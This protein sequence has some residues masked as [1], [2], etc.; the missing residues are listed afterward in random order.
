MNR[1]VLAIFK[2]HLEEEL[3]RPALAPVPNVTRMTAG[4]SFPLIL[5]LLSSKGIRPAAAVVS[6]GIYPGGKPDLVRELHAAFPAA[7]VVLAAR[8]PEP[9]PPLSRLLADG[10]RHVVIDAAEG[11]VAPS[12]LSEALQGLSADPAW[13]PSQYLAPGTPVAEFHPSSAD[14]KEQLI[15]RVEEAVG[16]GTPEREFLR[17]KAALLVDELLENALY[18]APV[19]DRGEKL[20]EKGEKREVGEGEKVSFRF[21]F[22][23]EVLAIEVSDGWGSLSP[24]AVV[25][26]LVKNSAAEPAADVGGRGLYIIWRFFDS[27]RISISPGRETRVTGHLHIAAPDFPPPRGL[28]LSARGSD[29]IIGSHN[30]GQQL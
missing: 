6:T 19:G 4:S 2:D 27:F 17:G 9:L 15:A 5:R 23:G 11:G 3:W 22:D 14:E 26:H 21:G 7:E 25:R 24:D 30:H 20:Y 8:F 16:G 10:I 12:P 13:T 18:G 1:S 28:F 29:Y